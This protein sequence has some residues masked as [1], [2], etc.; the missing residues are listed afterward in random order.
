LLLVFLLLLLSSPK[1]QNSNSDIWRS[2]PSLIQSWLAMVCLN[3]EQGSHT[4]VMAATTTNVHDTYLQPYWMPERYH[5]DVAVAVGPNHHDTRPPPPPF[6]IFEMMGPFVG[7]LATTPRLPPNA[8]AA[9]TAL[10]SASEEI[11]AEWMKKVK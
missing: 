11:I 8:A 2:L 9:G 4:S 7:S 5:Q 1:K 10:W 6:P 3:T